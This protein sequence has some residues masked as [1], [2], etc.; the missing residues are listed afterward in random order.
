MTS[1]L[2]T[3]LFACTWLR[4]LVQAFQLLYLLDDVDRGGKS[5]RQAG[6]SHSSADVFA[7][8][9]KNVDHKIRSPVYDES[10]PAK[11][12]GADDQAMDGDN[13]GSETPISPKRSSTWLICSSFPE[14]SHGWTSS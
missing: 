6:D 10:S 1:F 12:L 14:L 9:S 3:I 5:H 11:V 7:S 8:L 13:S 4:S 2:L